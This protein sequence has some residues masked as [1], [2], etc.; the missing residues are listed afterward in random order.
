MT[1]EI[2][3]LVKKKKEAY[4]RYRQLGLS[5]SLEEYDGSRSILKTGIRKPRRG[6]EIALAN[7]VKENPKRFYKYIKDKIVT[8]E[9]IGPLTKINKATL[10][11]ELQE[12]GVT[13]RID[14]GGT[15]DVVYMDFSKVLNKLLHGRLVSKVRSHGIQ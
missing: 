9:R 10:R 2:E 11:V 12:M 4:T 6:H 13:K 3:A 8:R 1:G 5:E 15:V 7:T 14:E